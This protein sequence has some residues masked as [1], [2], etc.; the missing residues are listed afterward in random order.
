VDRAERGDI[1]AM[2]AD[3]SLGTKEVGEL[4]TAIGWEDLAQLGAEYRT[5]RL[6]LVT[7]ACSELARMEPGTIA[8]RLG[9]LAELLP[10]RFEGAARA[11]RAVGAK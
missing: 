1:V 9:Q 7:W 11:H 6:R 10:M 4:F 5:E 8:D 2:I 3:Y